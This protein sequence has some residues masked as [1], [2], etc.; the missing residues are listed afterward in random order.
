MP[1]KIRIISA[2]NEQLIG[3]AEAVIDKI[4]PG[5]EMNSIEVGHG[6][7]IKDLLAFASSGNNRVRV[8]ML[9]S[10]ANLSKTKYLK[11]F[12]LSL[13]GFFGKVEYLL[14]NGNLISRGELLKATIFLPFAPFLLIVRLPAYIFSQVIGKFILTPEDAEDIFV[15]FGKEKKIGGVFYWLIFPPKTR[16]YGVFGLAAEN[17]WGMPLGIHSWPL[18][19][20]LLEKL[21]YRR[22]IYLAIGLLTTGMAWFTIE[23]EH[24]W[25]L[26]LLPFIL[27]SNYFLFNL[28]VGTWEL[29]SWGW[30]ML[31]FSAFQ[32]Q[33]PELSGVFFVLCLLSHPGV[34][35]LVGMMTVLFSL[36]SPGFSDAVFLFIRMGITGALLSL[37][38]LVPYYRTRRFS[39]REAIIN[40]HWQKIRPWSVS[41]AYQFLLCSLFAVV[42]T[43]SSGRPFL[44]LLLLLPPIIIFY[45]IKIRWVYSQYTTINFFI[46]LGFIFLVQFPGILSWIIFVYILFTSTKL[47]WSDGRNPYQGYDLTPVVLGKRRDEVLEAFKDVDSR[48]GLEMEFS[49]EAG[50]WRYTPAI[51]Y[52]LAET[53]IDLVNVAYS[54]IGDSRIIEKYCQYFNRSS[55]L[56]V[57]RRACQGCGVEYMTAFSAEFCDYLE[58]LGA[59]KIGGV[60]DICLTDNPVDKPV[61]IHVFRLPW[62]ISRIWP[63]VKISIDKNR[64]SFIARA[65]CVYTL[66]YSAFPGWRAFQNGKRLPV[67]DANPGIEVKAQTNGI[68]EL[69]YSL[70]HYWS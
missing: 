40:K 29:L 5:A 46:V 36:L 53:N 64:I 69:R 43:L 45:N 38:W 47:I 19:V 68:L 65:G 63:D 54:Q 26:L 3:W 55:S 14:R 59:E 58:A 16:K 21:G 42:A 51:G 49:M 10:A 22:F 66:K 15:G 57:F 67:C 31:A 23:N 6:F 1:A 48:A 50:T 35:S 39:G 52:M 11:V 37:W 56:E 7:R 20:L 25:L 28:Y 18:S 9:F 34:V 60:K 41:A 33:L 61:N 13:L 4:S 12:L 17:Y 27:A 30:G 62:K 32:A 8:I 2:Q 70:K 24:P 44:S